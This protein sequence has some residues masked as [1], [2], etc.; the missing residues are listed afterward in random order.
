MIGIFLVVVSLVIVSYFF[1]KT[2]PIYV[3][4]IWG[5]ITLKSLHPIKFTVNLLRTIYAL[6]TDNWVLY[7]LSYGFFALM[8]LLYD[9]GYIFYAF[10]LIDIMTLYP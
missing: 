8:G 2:A 5:S 4:H 6:L 1:F 9:G 10:L 7:Y 3:R